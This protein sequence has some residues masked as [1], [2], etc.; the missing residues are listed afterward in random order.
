MG[1]LKRILR[2]PQPEA[3]VLLGVTGT[4]ETLSQEEL[5]AHMAV[6]RYGEFELTDAIRPAYRLDIVPRQ[7]FR[8]DRY[9]EEASGV[10]IPVLMASATKSVLL[11]LFLDLL[12]PLGSIV[13][14]VLESSHRGGRF[15]P[16]LHRGQI[17]LPVLRSILL[18]H[19]H[20]L[21]NDGCTGIAVV[22]PDRGQEVQLDEHKTVIVYGEPLD[23][24]AKILIGSDVYPDPQIR[25][26]TEAEHIHS[27]NRRFLD[28]FDRL[29]TQLAM[30]HHP[31]DETV[32]W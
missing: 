23:G 22:C 9:R 20:L 15:R 25:F 18:E 29:C 4:F 11:D 30:D 21:L 12:E 10:D 16:D 5:R 14:V 3:G 28:E 1:F 17:D 27:S 32:G 24:F 19:E 8:H 13:D 26:I 7:G 6:A 2:S 31:G